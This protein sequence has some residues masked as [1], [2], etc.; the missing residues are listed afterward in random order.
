MLAIKVVK[1][2]FTEINRLSHFFVKQKINN[3]SSGTVTAVLSA[4]LLFYPILKA[5]H[6]RHVPKTSAPK[7]WANEYK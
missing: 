6:D 7:T 1:D 5:R 3:D 4:Y 2:K